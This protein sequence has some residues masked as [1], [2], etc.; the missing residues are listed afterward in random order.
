MLERRLEFGNVVPGEQRSLAAFD[1]VI[2]DLHWAKTADSM[3]PRQLPSRVLSI[4]F[5]AGQGRDD[6]VDVHAALVLFVVL[7]RASAIPMSAPEIR[8]EQRFRSRA[9]G[10]S[11][12]AIQMASGSIK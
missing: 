10:G 8:A 2:G 1:P 4:P 11:A 6:L 3:S 7:S 9:E 5:A 12:S